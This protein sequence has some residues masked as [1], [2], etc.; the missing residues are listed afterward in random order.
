MALQIVKLLDPIQ[1]TISGTFTPRGAYDGSTDYGVGDQVD[2]NGSSYIMYSDAVAGTLP[3][4]T[5]FWG[6]VASKGDAGNDSTVPGPPGVVQSVVAGTNI[7][8]DDTD[9]ANPIVSTTT[10]GTTK[11]FVIAMAAAL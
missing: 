4:D 8:V 7:S 5:S 3:T 9:P 11:G 6:L 10:G 2:Y 1:M